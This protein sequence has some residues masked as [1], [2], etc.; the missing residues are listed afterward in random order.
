MTVS[1]GVETVV[2]VGTTVVV[3][4][5][6]TGPVTGAVIYTWQLSKAATPSVWEDAGQ[7]TGAR[8]SFDDLTPG[9]VYSVRINAVGTAGASDWSNPVSQMVI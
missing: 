5:T 8:N 7:T 3:T 2:D 4:G 9:V 6:V 1:T